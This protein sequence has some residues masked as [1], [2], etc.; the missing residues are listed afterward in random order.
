LADRIA[1]AEGRQLSLRT[2]DGGTSTGVVTDV[3]RD[4]L[5]LRHGGWETFHRLSTIMTISGLGRGS[6]PAGSLTW[7]S[8]GSVW[9]DWVARRRRCQW[10]LVDRRILTGSVV[11]V[12]QDALDVVEH[13]VDR[14]AVTSDGR[15]VLP[16]TAIS[17]SRSRGGLDRD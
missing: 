5:V 17:W 12:G 7:A 6:Q 2:L 3:G 1:A 16:L 10:G 11:R 14:A 9:R 13:P 8:E 15:V 4:W